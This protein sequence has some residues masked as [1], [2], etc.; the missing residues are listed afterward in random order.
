MENE[1]DLVIIGASFEGLCLAHYFALNKK[2]VAIIESD[3]IKKISDDDKSLIL[4]EK[5]VEVL[6]E[7]F[8]IRIP[9]KFIENSFKSFNLIFGDKEEMIESESYLINEKQ[10][11]FYLIG[12][13]IELENV[14]FFEKTN[15]VDFIMDNK[16]IAGVKIKTP[17]SEELK[18]KII[19]DASESK[20][21][22]RSILKDNAY[23]S[24]FIDEKLKYP[25]YE[26][27]VENIDVHG[28][29]FI[30][31]PEKK[32]AGFFSIIPKNNGKAIMRLN[33]FDKI[34]D[35]EK[36]MR[37]YLDKNFSACKILKSKKEEYSIINPFFGFCY[38]N[39]LLVGSSAFQL[40]PFLKED[41]NLKLNACVSICKELENSFSIPDIYTNDLWNYN[42]SFMRKYGYKLNFFNEIKS[43][44]L[45]LSSQEI[46]YLFESGNLNEW[47]TKIFSNEINKYSLIMPLILKPSLMSKIMKFNYRIE[48]LKQSYSKY[49]EFDDFIV[50]KNGLK[51]LI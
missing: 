26:A 6:K 17:A 34:I 5:N 29:N 19:I 1:Y 12:K 46:D 37:E 41:A 31:E 24:K 13:I 2:K 22:A 4:S 43:L 33:L 27:L 30:I 32:D 11:L 3:S 35:P 14:N 23:F 38:Q 18:A 21:A 7:F 44:I 39:F 28:L 10:F 42:I 45:N 15:F 50:W 36:Y 9:S 40:N 49:P 25:C 48:K 51:D 20:S 47:V 16:R 8:N